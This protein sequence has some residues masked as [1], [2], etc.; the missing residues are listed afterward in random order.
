MITALKSYKRFGI[1]LAVVLAVFGI[2][3]AVAYSQDKPEAG[4]EEGIIYVWSDVCHHC[5]N[6]TPK[7][8]QTLASFP[9][10]KVDRWNINQDVQKRQ[11]AVQLGAEG[12]PT[13][14]A[15]REGKVVDK[16]VGDVSE[17]EVRRFIQR[18]LIDHPKNPS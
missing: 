18:N 15:V 11:K 9:D 6:F 8:D 7:F 12:T 5:K 1:F 10:L 17:V 4:I 2:L 16:L 13:V 3:A 14:F